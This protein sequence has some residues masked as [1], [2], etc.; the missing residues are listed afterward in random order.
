MVGAA[1]ASPGIGELVKAGAPDFEMG[2]GP[3]GVAGAG[4][5]GNLLPALD[6]VP[7]THAKRALFEMIVA[8]RK[9]A[10]N[11][12]VTND[13]H[14]AAGKA[15]DAA[16]ATATAIWTERRAHRGAY[17]CIRCEARWILAIGFIG[18]RALI[19]LAV[20]GEQNH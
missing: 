10:R 15:Q 18:V 11:V 14:V 4:G 19:V 17:L 7:R 6:V 5:F 1:R 13:K 9:D 12:Q 20:E 16:S 3:A 2:M 8:S